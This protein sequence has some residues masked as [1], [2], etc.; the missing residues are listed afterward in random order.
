MRAAPIALAVA[1]VAT[2]CNGDDDAAT[3]IAPPVTSDTLFVTTTTDPPATTQPSTT[4]SEPSTVPSSAV[5]D[6]TSTTPTSE[7]PPTTSDPDPELEQIR[8]DVAAAVVESWEAFNDVVRDPSNV[9]LT[10]RL[11][12][13]S[14]EDEFRGIFDRF[15]V[16]YITFDLAER[17]NQAVPSRILPDPDSLEVDLVSGTA[18]MSYCLIST[19]LLV[20]I[21]DDG[22]ET[23]ED[24]TVAVLLGTD[25]FVLVDGR[26]I[27]DGGATTEVLE[28][29]DECPQA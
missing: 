17:T 23:V 18:S 28:G 13:L 24:D 21:Q 8:Q 1:L 6:T 9:E 20:Q 14:T 19:N 29:E 10:D 12:A 16:R 26:W 15:I 4:V 27:D 2:A 25:S 7:A 3:T 5:E 22:S 11:Q